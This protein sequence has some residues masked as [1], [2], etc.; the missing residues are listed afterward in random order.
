M[1]AS[2][3]FVKFNVIPVIVNIEKWRIYILGVIPGPYNEKL[4]FFLTITKISIAIMVPNMPIPMVIIPMVV[5]S[6]SSLVKKENLGNMNN[7]NI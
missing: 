1:K 6:M 7:K 5:I 4:K 2:S 3:Q